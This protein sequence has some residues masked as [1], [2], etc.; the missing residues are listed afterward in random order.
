MTRRKI[1]AYFE[2]QL[3]AK[4]KNPRW[5]WGAVDDYHRIFLRIWQDNIRDLVDGQFVW[6]MGPPAA[7]LGCLMEFNTTNELSGTFRF[8]GFVERTIR[9]GI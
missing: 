3:R 6:I 1:N 2:D 8:K 4:V 9:M 5:S 7:M